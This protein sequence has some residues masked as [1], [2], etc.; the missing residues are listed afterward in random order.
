ML[1]AFQVRGLHRTLNVIFNKALK[2]AQNMYTF[3]P[4]LL[5]IALLLT[6]LCFKKLLIL[7]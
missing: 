1:F 7:I 4:S 2:T 6:E 5:Q 3:L